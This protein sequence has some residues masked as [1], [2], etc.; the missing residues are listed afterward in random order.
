L[1]SLE[2]GFST[3]NA[4]GRFC[5][6]R[7]VFNGSC[8][9]AEPGGTGS[10]FDC[11]TWLHKARELPREQ[12]KQEVEKELTGQETEPWEIVYFKFYKSQTPCH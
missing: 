8:R 10:I 12:F 5:G 9:Q 2:C 6:F 3:N 1:P 11:A 4:A 7:A